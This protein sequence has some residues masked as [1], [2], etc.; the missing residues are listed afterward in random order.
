MTH[1]I[2][3]LYG[4]YRSD[5]MGIRLAQFIV[6]GLR[7]RGDDVELIDAKAVGL[8]MLDRMYKEHPKGQA[9]A[10]LEELAGKIRGA[11]GFV[12]ITG[13]YNWGMQ[14]GLKNLTDHFLEEWFWRPAAIVS[15]SAG[16]LSGA[17]AATAWHGTLSEMGMVVISSTIGVGPIAQTLSDDGKPTG[18]AGKALERAFPRFADDLAWWVEAAKA[19]RAKKAPPY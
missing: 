17:R 15:Y 1:R 7:G 2:L 4:S 11:D 12:F 3:V 18:E 16:R 6:E 8:P 13:E 19:Q 10:V 9:P 14:P 5:R